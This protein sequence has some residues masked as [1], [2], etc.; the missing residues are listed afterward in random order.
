[1]QMENK[2]IRQELVSS[3]MKQWQ[4]ADLMGISEQTIYRKLRKELPQAEQE[5]IIKLIQ[6][7]CSV[8]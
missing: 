8:C 7:R 4:L 2:L 1:M 3:G 6:S 5:Q